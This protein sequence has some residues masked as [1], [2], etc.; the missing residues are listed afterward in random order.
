MNTNLVLATLQHIIPSSRMRLLRVFVST[1]LVASSVAPA[2]AQTPGTPSFSDVPTDH[3]AFAAIE[4]LKAN[5]IVQGYPD[6]TFHPNEAVNRAAAVKIIVSPLVQA[7]MLA[8]ITGTGYKDV[9]GVA[10]WAAPYL[11]VA[12]GPLGIIDGPPKTETFRP[13]DPVTK[14]EFLKMLLLAYKSL[15]EAPVDPISMFS[16]I[17]LPLSSDVND[18][19]AWFYPYM[20]Y[21]IASSMTT[22]DTQG[23]LSPGK[24]LTRGE[25]AVLLHRFLMYRQGLRKQ[26]LLSLT[27]TEILNI[28]KLLD[29]NTI[30]QAN[31]ASNRGYVAARGALASSYTPEEEPLIKGAVKTSEGFVALVDAYEEGLK[32]NLQG[33]LDSAANAWHLAEK[34]REFTPSLDAI[35]SQMQQIAKQMADQARAA[36]AAG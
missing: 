19:S 6:G 12:R 29:E 11:E 18:P 14:A 30:D 27:E 23:L 36:L 20:R 10:D 8:Q 16:E 13:A 33:V 21:A 7:D 4:F 22:T 9:R 15:P 26:A 25:V 17:R 1:L 35:A 34:A 31:F 2:L 28:L 32:G 3:Y 24:T 5:N